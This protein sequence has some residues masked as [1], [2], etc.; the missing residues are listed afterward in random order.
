MQKDAKGIVV[1]S[2]FVT[3]GK[4]DLEVPKGMPADVKERRSAKEQPCKSSGN[5]QA[6]LLSKQGT[7]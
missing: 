6:S 5:D 4:G 7:S 1:E 3:F 2:K